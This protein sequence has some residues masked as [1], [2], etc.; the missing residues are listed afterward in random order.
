MLDDFR[1]M[2]EVEG[3]AD[4][5]FGLTYLRAIANDQKVFGPIQNV[6]YR[7]FIVTPEN[8]TIF[9][10]SKNILTYMEF[11]KQFYLK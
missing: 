10:K 9:L 2:V 5:A 6:N 11:Y 4:R 8:E 3:L 1:V 7:N